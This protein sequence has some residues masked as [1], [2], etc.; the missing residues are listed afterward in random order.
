MSDIIKNL[1]TTARVMGLEFLFIRGIAPKGLGIETAKKLGYRVYTGKDGIEKISTVSYC[2][3][4]EDSA[5]QQFWGS[6]PGDWQ[7]GADQILFEANR[8]FGMYYVTGKGTGFN[9]SDISQCNAYFY[10][11]DGMPMAEQYQQL[12][13]TEGR[14]A[15]PASLVTQ[16]KNS[17][18]SY[19]LQE[20]PITDIEH[21][22]VHQSRF[23]GAM[24]S[25]P[26]CKNPA[27][28]MRLPGFDHLSIED[29]EIIRTPVKLIKAERKPVNNAEFEALWPKTQ[30]EIAREQKASTHFNPQYRA[31]SD[32]DE[33]AW[34]EEAINYAPVRIPGAGTYGSCRDALW[35]LCSAVGV[36]RAISLYEYRSPSHGDWCV[37]TV[38]GQY[39]PARSAHPGWFWKLAVDGG[40]VPPT[41]KDA[42]VFYAKP[43]VKAAQVA[44]AKTQVCLPGDRLALVSSAAKAE[45]LTEYGFQ[46]VTVGRGGDLHPG[47]ATIAKDKIFDLFFDQEGE[48]FWGVKLLG[49]L[50]A[51]GA[52]KGSQLIWWDKKQS[53]SITGLINT[54]AACGE[55]VGKSLETIVLKSKLCSAYHRAR[56]LYNQAPNRAVESRTVS[57][58][59]LG[60]ELPD[61]AIKGGEILALQSGTG[62]GKTTAIRAFCRVANG[63]GKIVIVVSPTN[64][65][66]KQA[67]KNLGYPHRH[68]W[69]VW[70]N[71]LL[72]AQAEEAGGIVCC[73]DSLAKVIGLVA[74][75]EYVVIVDEADQVANHI[76][77]GATLKGK[78]G[79]VLSLYSKLLKEAWAVVL[80][81]ARLPENTL[82]FHELASGKETRLI[83]HEMTSHKRSV[84]L[85]SGS[86]PG[87]HAKIMA[88][89]EAGEKIIITVDSQRE[90]EKLHRVIGG[91]FP[92]INIIRADAHTAYLPE[93]QTLI[94]TPNQYLAANNIDCLIYSP[95]C[96]SGWDL[97][98]GGYFFNRVFGFFRVLPT[99][100]Q[101]QQLARYRGAADWEVFCTPV[102]GVPDGQSQGLRRRAKDAESEI[103]RIVAEFE[104]VYNPADRHKLEQ[105]ATD[106]R[107]VFEV[108]SSLENSI[109]YHAMLM[110][111]QEDGHQVTE[112]VAENDPIVAE[113]LEAAAESITRDWAALVAQQEI[114]PEST[115]KRAK[116]LEQVEA[117]TPR[118][119]AEAAKIRAHDKHGSVVDLNDVAVV[120]Q[121]VKNHGK[122]PAGANLE[123]G[124][125]NLA[126]VL[127]QQKKA[128]T[129]VFKD[130]IIAYHHLGT[131]AQRCGLIAKSGVLEL[132][133][134]GEWYDSD[135]PEIIA[136]KD[137]CLGEVDSW[138][139]Y[140]RFQWSVDMPA[141]KFFTALARKLGY[142]LR[143]SRSGGGD[144]TYSYK[145][146]G[147]EDYQALLAFQEQS[148]AEAEIKIL[149]KTARIDKLSALAEERAAR[150]EKTKIRYENDEATFDLLQ[151]RERAVES[152]FEPIGKCYG[153]ID[154]LNA[155]IEARRRGLAKIADK[156]L[157]C[158]LRLEILGADC[159]RYSQSSTD[160][161][162]EAAMQSVDGLIGTKQQRRNLVEDLPPI[163]LCG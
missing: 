38:A 31:S 24:Q 47:L 82:R 106:H 71:E 119:R 112:V 17:L 158:V 154:R 110:R 151:K 84:N 136:L 132:L 116:Q 138:R 59:Y 33:F 148:I 114:T 93:V 72:L 85:Y 160:C 97:T 55:D 51:A 113:W 120:Y 25:D 21:W 78:Y 145:V 13:E 118:Q 92:A 75:F 100:D 2:Y 117:P 37:R 9:D 53:N 150:V 104:I 7:R 74:G 77:Q 142:L 163:N 153:A 130:E 46:C 103:A 135:S 6:K 52:D 56:A 36:S 45:A 63:Q 69:H 76:T 122:L 155:K 49:Q 39:D 107:H 22:K 40:W 111:L 34:V 156:I 15:V 54:L 64:N 89:L 28:L 128:T 1:D 80:A 35:G 86:I 157:Y 134:T 88:A 101:I 79:Q 67:A 48:N 123:A 149:T 73:P 98:G 62:S 8:R 50:K 20:T 4:V 87:F 27:R 10:E 129:E 126:A 61:L 105:V 19:W 144:R 60:E 108:R 99:S 94:T 102:A 68:D 57:D 83:C 141:I 91:R 43:V 96:K 127:H 131:D 41:K 95:A 139:R 5:L 140:F 162:F 109:N 65:L 26:A 30:A 143:S 124:A 66:G 11:I 121:Y 12:A 81:E 42:P 152:T 137:R 146:G 58:K 115:L 125:R 29:G 32:F 147:V 70:Q 16:T 23:I 90:G 133:S 161:S 159:K 18:H 3:R 44:E 14:V